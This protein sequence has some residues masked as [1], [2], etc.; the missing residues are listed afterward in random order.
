[1]Q[2]THEHQATEKL[3]EVSFPSSCKLAVQ[4][5]CNRWIALLHSFSCYADK[6]FREV[7][8][9]SAMCN[10]AL[11]RCMTRTNSG[12][13]ALRRTLMGLRKESNLAMRIGGKTEQKILLL[14]RKFSL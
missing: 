8:A 5:H 14:R 7:G 13:R 2:N 1:M 12:N 9:R 11:G 3:G 10:G 6:V 4:R